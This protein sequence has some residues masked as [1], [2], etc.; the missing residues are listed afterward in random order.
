[1]IIVLVVIL[2]FSVLSAYGIYRFFNPFGDLLDKTKSSSYFYTKKGDA[3]LYCSNGNWFSLG[4]SKMDVDKATFIV[5]SEN[6]AKDKNYAYYE[7]EKILASIDLA[8]FDVKEGYIPID[9][10]NVYTFMPYDEKYNTT[11]ILKPIV[12]ADPKTYATMDYNWSIDKNHVFLYD[13]VVTDLD[14][15]SFKVLSSC[16]CLDKSG[17]Y[18][19]NSETLITKTKAN[20]QETEVLGD[21]YI[22]DDKAV[23]YYDNGTF[24]GEDS[25]IE[26]PNRNRKNVQLYNDFYLRIDTTVYFQAKL[27]KGIDSPSMEVFDYRYAKDINNVFFDGE[28]MEEAD[29]AT[30]RKNKD[31]FTFSDKNNT[32]RFGEIITEKLN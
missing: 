5:L 19:Y 15:S 27:V 30:F 26:M 16:F 18:Y 2:G 13:D 23:Y 10:N 17:V 21:K 31:D 20:S 28:I 12:E 1:M 11:N 4:E 7:S 29:V 22:C 32:Y 24:S 9:K 6:Y 14:V 8:T 3:I 25:F